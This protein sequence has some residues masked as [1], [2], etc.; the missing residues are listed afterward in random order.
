MEQAGIHKV[1][2]Q[3]TAVFHISMDSLNQ[4]AID[5]TGA[6]RGFWVHL[7]KPQGGKDSVIH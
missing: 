5:C 1:G 2:G 4:N 6:G 7:Y 3:S